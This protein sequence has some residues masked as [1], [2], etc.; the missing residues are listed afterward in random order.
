MKNNNFSYFVIVGNKKKF[1]SKAYKILGYIIILYMLNILSC[2][3][4]GKNEFNL[5]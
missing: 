3:V 5:L 4:F 2:K 1:Y